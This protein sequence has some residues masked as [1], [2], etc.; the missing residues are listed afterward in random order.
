MNKSWPFLF[1]FLMF[2]GVAFFSP[3]LVLYYQE[4]GFSATQIGLL[5][6]V[7]P[8]ITLVSAPLWTG[9]A[10][11]TQRHRLVMTVTLLL[12]IVALWLFPLARLFI[13]V[14]LIAILLN[15][16]LAP[17]TAFADSATMFM[18]GAGKGLYGRVRLGGT[19]GFGLLAP[20]AGAVVQNYGLKLAFWGG[21]ILF[22][23][24]LIAGQKLTHSRVRRETSL[25]GNLRGLLAD[26]RWLLFLALAFAG[27]LSVAVNNNYFF[28][29]MKELGAPESMMGVALSIATLSELPVL[30]FG[31]R[32]LGRFN[33][34]GLLVLAMV[35]T[36]L[37]LLLLAATGNPNL[38]L[39]IQ[40]LGGLTFPAMWIA[41][42]AYADER[43]PAGMAATAQGLFGAMVFGFGAAVGG[44]SGSLLLATI[45]GRGM[46]LVF[47]LA[48]LLTVTAVALLETRLPAETQPAAL[49]NRDG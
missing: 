7:T 18:L 40:L 19:I 30:F 11:A 23:L 42:V 17:V 15:S 14:A 47:G 12:C 24:A 4:L 28:P 1:Y 27:G 2:A 36:G 46:N 49:V 43:A 32:L 22:F 8:L 44:V 37:R 9:L 26:R 31:N 29:Y 21:S 45:G 16:A 13:P 3:F 25:R 39:L 34:Y 20:I 33:A 41:G 35:V 6:G 10:D 48:V 5:T 38:V